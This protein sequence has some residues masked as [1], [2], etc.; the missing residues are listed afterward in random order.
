MP[1]SELHKTKLSKALSNPSIETRK[2]MSS[3]S[4]NRSLLSK[5]RMSISASKPQLLI[6]CPH[7]GKEGGSKTM[8]RWHFNNCK[9]IL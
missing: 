1:L 6:T 3:A 9:S 4:S 5:Q 2:K 8:P 7:C